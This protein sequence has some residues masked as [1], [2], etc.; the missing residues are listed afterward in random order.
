M[1]ILDI[2]NLTFKYS[3]GYSNAL[4]NISLKVCEGDFVLLLGASGSGKT[5][6]LRLLK[7]ELAPFGE[8]SGEINFRNNI[9]VAMV[10][11]NVENQMVSDTV[12][13]NIAFGL[14]SMNLESN[15]IRQTVAEVAEFFDI[16]HLFHKK[17]AMLSGG[18][19]Q[20]V[21]LASVMATNPDILLLD[22]P[23]SQL[24]PIATRRFIDMIKRL[25]SEMGLTVIISEHKNE[26]LFNYANKICILKNGKIEFEGE[27]EEVKYKD[28]DIDFPTTVRIFNELEGFGRCPVTVGDCRKFL[29]E[30]YKNNIDEITE[31][32][33]DN[34]KVLEAQD[35]YFRYE[36]NSADVLKKLNFSA[37]KGEIL[38][39]IGGNG[40]GK[41]TLLSV[42]G[43]GLKPYSGKIKNKF[44][45]IGVLPQNVKAVFTKDC[46]KDDLSVVTADFQDIVKNLQIEHLL[47]RNPYDLSGGEAQRA[48][49]AK[50]L[51]IE[52]DILC[53]DEPTKGIDAKGRREVGKILR[54][55][56]EEGKS[57][58]IVTHD[59]DFAADYSDKCA[60]LY[61]G[62]IVSEG[63]PRE[64]LSK[65]KFYTTSASIISRH[66]YKNAVTVDDVVYLC[67]RNGSY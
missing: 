23:T 56:A 10:T 35:L 7:E 45:K 51:L 42:L 20:L 2:K 66:M 21:T 12:W 5:T 9:R 32:P 17:T 44:S 30:N 26:E 47:N 16:T 13:H 37:H 27:G 36:K 19:K 22:E 43:G 29:S 33:S 64:V 25:N 62:Q 65:N 6:L 31:S 55:L 34:I 60:F 46:L 15:V 4:E 14:E 41:T 54:N 24:D 48:A 38:T 67:K 28:S 1:E 40:T 39:L 63:T 52:P 61:D 18:E 8:K 59:T 50:I 53:L 11:Q 3:T 49:L 57:I 58:I